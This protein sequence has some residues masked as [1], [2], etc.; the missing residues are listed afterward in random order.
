MIPGVRNGGGDVSFGLSKSGAT[1]GTTTSRTTGGLN[2]VTFE[3]P[4]IKG[5]GDGDCEKGPSAKSTRRSLSCISGRLS[6]LWL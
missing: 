2:N 6:S 3:N 5:G 4:P 1:V